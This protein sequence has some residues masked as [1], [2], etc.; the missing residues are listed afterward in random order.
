MEAGADFKVVNRAGKD[1]VCEAEAGEKGE[2]AAWLLTGGKGAESGGGG[3]GKGD[4][5]G[6]GEDGGVDGRR[7]AEV[8][9]EGEGE[10]EL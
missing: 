4:V 10:G 5:R 2:V 3:G 6:G 8:V 9:M 7:G 1:A